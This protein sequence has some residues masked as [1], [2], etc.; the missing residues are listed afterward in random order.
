M[1]VFTSIAIILVGMY[2]CVLGGQVALFYALKLP[3]NISLR[4]RLR[5]LLVVIT[6]VGITLGLIA[7]A[8]R[9]FAIP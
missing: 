3:V 4:F 7:S 1:L 5:S 2:L 6:V 9:F 8:A